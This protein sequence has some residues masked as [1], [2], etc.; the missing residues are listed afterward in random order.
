MPQP[1]SLHDF[2][3]DGIREMVVDGILVP[4]TSIDE[5]AVATSLGVSRGPIRE[6]LKVL[7][8]EGIVEIRPR[9]GAQVV[10][11]TPARVSDL[12]EVIGNLEA[13]AIR[14]VCERASDS[15]L[16]EID[17]LNEAMRSHFK[18]RNLRLY[19][20]LNQ[21]IHERIVEVS[22]N[23]MLVEIYGRIATRARMA[24]FGV[25]MSNSRWE[26]AMSEHDAIVEA[27]RQR[28]GDRAANLIHAHALAVSGVLC[29]QLSGA[30][31]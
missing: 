9:R 10:Q 6:A 29:R 24:R 27:L 28:D 12:Y 19:S 3:V 23:V 22:A 20:D 30:A 11:L 18:R 5:M 8:A 17:G 1:D 15:E 7:R 2:V 25:E 13:L 16:S 14:H 21:Q 31:E 4:G 26:E